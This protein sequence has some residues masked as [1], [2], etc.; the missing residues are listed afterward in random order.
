MQYDSRVTSQKWT[1]LLCGMHSI[2]IELRGADFN[3]ANILKQQDCSMVHS[4]T[5]QSD[6]STPKNPEADSEP[7][8]DSSPWRCKVAKPW[9]SALFPSDVNSGTL[10]AKAVAA[11][12][13][14]ALAC[15][16]LARVFGAGATNT[17][18]A[19]DGKV[20]YE[21]SLHISPARA[22][23]TPYNGYLH[24]APRVLAALSRCVPLDYLSTFF[25][26]SGALATSLLAV[27]VWVASRPLL[28]Q[29]AL[30]VAVA[31]PVALTWVAQSE[32]GNNVVDLQWYLLYAAFW[33]ALWNV[34]SIS[35][36]LVAASVIFCSIASDPLTLLYL[37]LLFARIWVLRSRRDWML[38]LGVV[39][40]GTYQGYGAVF[41]SSL[42][43]RPADKRYDPVWSAWGYVINVLGRAFWSGPGHQVVS[44]IFACVLAGVAFRCPPSARRHPLVVSSIVFSI[45]LY[46]A[47]TL[48]GGAFAERYAAPSSALLIAGVAGVAA[49][50][51][52]SVDVVALMQK[53]LGKLLCAIVAACVALGFA[54]GTDA[55]LR[56]KG[57]PWSSQL[58][59]AEVFCTRPG[60][61]FATMATAPS[62]K[63][64]TVTVPC[65][66]VLHR[67]D[68]FQ[69]GL[70]ANQQPR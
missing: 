68:W 26:I 47:L 56:G 53:Q 1:I 17:I 48:S 14:T 12:V 4:L 55:Q 69:T 60:A 29:A 28:E 50:E 6:S 24:F 27:F 39:L 46:G 63:G 5:S 3:S 7:D 61:D 19:E 36:R 21:D 31:A 40:G 65:Q 42:S 66:L 59:Q 45:I 57:K 13:A 35:G 20:F 8:S 32:L 52:L 41:M 43:S 30:R 54:S 58:D 22:L 64:W 49:E 25:A 62:G 9:L 10:K 37:P 16:S 51:G 23:V 33:A 15:L 38:A 34:E 18:W 67:D 2:R 44:I 11:L 70:Y